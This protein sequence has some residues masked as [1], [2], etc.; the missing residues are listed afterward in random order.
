MCEG[1]LCQDSGSDA[2]FHGMKR[3]CEGGLAEAGV[4]EDGLEGGLGDAG[5]VPAGHAGVLLPVGLIKQLQQTGHQ[6]S[7]MRATSNEAGIGL[8]GALQPGLPVYQQSKRSR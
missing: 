5:E 8:C 3:T 7:S 2:W 1:R 6:I 4:L